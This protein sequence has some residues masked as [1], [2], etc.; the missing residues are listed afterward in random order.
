MDIL[1]RA[2]VW[3][4]IAFMLPLNGVPRGYGLMLGR[5]EPSPWTVPVVELIF[6]PSFL[7]C[8][9]VQIDLDDA[10]NLAVFWN[11]FGA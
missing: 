7:S 3:E 10:A 8:V 9:I 4:T 1:S 6:E 5:L 2:Y 11:S